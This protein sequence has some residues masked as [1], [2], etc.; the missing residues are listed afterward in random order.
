MLSFN[1]V[2]QSALYIGGDNNFDQCLAAVDNV[3]FAE[4]THAVHIIDA[5]VIGRLRVQSYAV[6]EGQ[7]CQ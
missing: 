6:C 5:D 1:T 7:S 4:E 2:L 3:S